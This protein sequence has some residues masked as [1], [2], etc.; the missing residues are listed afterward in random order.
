M[1]L[2]KQAIAGVEQGSLTPTLSRR[3]RE[4]RPA[5]GDMPAPRPSEPSRIAPANARLSP[6]RPAAHPLLLP[7]GEG[8]DEGRPLKSSRL[9]SWPQDVSN[10]WKTFLSMN[11][12]SVAAGV[13]PAVE[14][15]VSPPESHGFMV[16]YGSNGCESLPWKPSR[17]L[18][19]APSPQ[20]T[21]G[22]RGSRVLPS[23]TC[24]NPS[25]RAVANRSSQGLAQ[26]LETRGDSSP[27]PS[28][29]RPG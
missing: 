23:A 13:P 3:E 12:L 27:S 5:L 24:L 16:S 1:S 20:P 10:S 2:A 17:G 22:G 15:G 7:P 26:L 21:P 14:G 19:P 25:L 28:G 29:R 9:G 6:P 18:K 11:L 8:R 4:S